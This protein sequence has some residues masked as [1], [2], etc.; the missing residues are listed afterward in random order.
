MAQTVLI[1][2]GSGKIGKHAAEAF[3]NAGWTVRHYKRGTDMTAQAQGV[4]VIVNGLNP[5]KYNDW[6]KN[7]P[8][9]TS[10]VIAAAQSSGATV[11]VPGNVY[12]FG[13]KGGIWDEATPQAPVTEKGHIRVAMEAAY[14]DAGVQTII[15]RAGH[16]IDPGQD[17][18]AYS[19]VHVA[20]V[21]KGVVTTLGDPDA[22]QAHAYLP[23]W[24]RAA[25][26]LAAMRNDLARFEDIPF[27]GHSF[28]INQ[29]RDEMADALGKPMKLSYF[30]WRLMAFVAPFNE[31]IREFRKMRYLPNTS[32]QL[33][34]EKFDR[35]LPDFK[36]TDLRTALL[37]GVPSDVHPD[38]V[39][40]ASGQAIV[41]Q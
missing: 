5:P 27:P 40:H 3:W 10:Q 39:V 8:A 12:N 35:L 22:M 29:L 21:G 7:I 32:H 6:A 18:D 1:L 23:D 26:K 14:R 37:S 31:M 24:A 41:A 34:H 17:G 20:K 16:F 2:G 28:T 9:I 19:M 15:L 4:D 33:G 11:I 30:P 13:D 36:P 38:K 25:V